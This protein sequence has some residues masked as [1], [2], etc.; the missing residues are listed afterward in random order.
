MPGDYKGVSSSPTEESLPPYSSTWEVDHIDKEPEKR[1]NWRSRRSWVLLY[2]TGPEAFQR[3]WPRAWPVVKKLQPTWKQTFALT[4]VVVCGILPLTLLGH[5]VGGNGIFSGVF[6]DKIQTC[7]DSFGTPEN[8]T[9]T[10]IE[11]LF[12]LD[13]T[14]GKFSFSQAKTIDVVW[15]TLIGRGVQMFA[16]WIGYKVFS[17]ALLRAIERHPA[18][19]E[20]FQRIALEGPSLLSLWTLIKEQWRSRSKRTKALFFY[21]F[22]STLYIVSIPMF[23]SAMTG[24]DS[25]SI[26]WV[27]LDDQN[28]NNIV[29]AS[30]LEQA[31]IVTRAGN[32]TFGDGICVDSNLYNGV[33]NALSIRRAYC[34]SKNDIIDASH[35][36]QRR[37]L[38]APQRHHPNSSGPDPSPLER[39]Y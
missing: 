27:S 20:I 22:L 12:V 31:W 1:W 24:Y 37:R 36:T 4:L 29:A 18:S 15:D 3:L 26:A 13:S 23:L 34:E 7:G 8:A 28:Q 16:W 25:T 38:P 11:K 39:L 33:Y 6:S 32:D 17:D 19:F 5:F 9:V 14:F 10:G 2:R 30:M 21:I 35:L